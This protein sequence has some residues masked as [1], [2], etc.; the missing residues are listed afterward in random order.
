MVNFHREM[1]QRLLELDGK[2]LM[3]DF[4]YSPNSIYQQQK[5][6]R[7]S[8]KEVQRVEELIRQSY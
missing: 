5:K 2:F 8:K 6:L 4:I 7:K 1:R 3:Q